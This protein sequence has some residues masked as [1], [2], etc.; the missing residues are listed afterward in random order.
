MKTK[1]KLHKPLC[2]FDLETTGLDIINDK[3]IEISIVKVNPNYSKE[4]KTW[5]V[6][7]TIHINPEATKVHGYTNEMLEDCPTFEEICG[8]IYDMICDSDLG[9]YNSDKFDIP[10]LVEEFFKVGIDITELNFKTIDVQTIFHKYERR[11]LGAAYEFYCGKELINAH[12]AEADIVAT[13]E[14][15]ESQIE[16]YNLSED[17]NEL[18]KITTPDRVDFGGFMYYDEEG[19]EIFRFGK[20]KNQVVKEVFKTDPSYYRWLVYTSDF[21][22][23]SKKMFKLIKERLD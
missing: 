22:L 12:S 9:G 6:N 10:F 3:I 11:N 23:H 4:I 8:D 5:K 13:L 2:F 21:S 18:S 19:R 20:Y 17:F 15:L 7:P 16:K 1:I 14:I